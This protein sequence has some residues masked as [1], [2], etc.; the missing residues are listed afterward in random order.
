MAGNDVINKVLKSVE[1]V[2]LN[3]ITKNVKFQIMT[4][5]KKCRDFGSNSKL[6]MDREK[7]MVQTVTI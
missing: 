4:N 6:K 1:M 3:V 7:T 2:S 5:S